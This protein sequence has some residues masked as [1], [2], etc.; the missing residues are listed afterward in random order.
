MKPTLNVPREMVCKLNMM[1]YGINETKYPNRKI[2]PV[3]LNIKYPFAKDILEGTHQDIEELFFTDLFKMLSR[4][5]REMTAREVAERQGE[6]ITGLSGP[7]TRQNAEVLRPLIK[8]TFNILMRRG[9]LL[10]PPPVLQQTGIPLD[11]EFVGLL[12]MAQRQYYRSSGLNRGIAFV[13]GIAEATQDLSV[14]DNVNTDELVRHAM[15]GEG[16]PQTAIEELPVVQAKR[17]ARAKALQQQQALERA[18]QVA[19]MVPNLNKTPEPGSAGEAI[20]QRLASGQT[21]GAA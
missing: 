8:R 12:A 19:G 4:A 1:P 13:A 17:E 11:I 20:S 7:L 3:E 18:E 21:G 6:R 5:Q 2:T 16:F 15:D 14:W 9:Y 10:P